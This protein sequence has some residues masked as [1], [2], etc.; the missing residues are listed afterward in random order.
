MSRYLDPTNDVAF[1]KI[2]GTD[3]HK[4]LL[5][6]FLNATLGLTG[7]EMIQTIEFLQK[8]QVPQI[9][10]NKLTILDVKCKTGQGTI[11][12][13]EIQNKVVPE[14]LKRTQYYASHCY[15]NQLNSGSTYLELSPVVLLAIVNYTLFPNKTGRVVSFHKTLDVESHEHDHQAISYAY[16]ELPKF[17]KKEDELQTVQD[18]WIF[19]LKNWKHSK[20]IPKSVQEKEIIEAYQ[21]I[22]QFGW[23]PFEMDEYVRA[24]LF[25]TDL[26]RQQQVSYEEGLEKGLQE[27]FEK[28][29]LEE[30][31]HLAQQLL[32]KG[33]SQ[34]EVSEMIQLRV[35]EIVKCSETM[36]KS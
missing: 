30:K 8:E 7:Q 11:F 31:F 4:P 20:E 2:F 25:R 27:G 32:T 17:E 15:V 22:E 23:N 16:I 12:I 19:F 10:D 28:G 29:R 26:Y 34:Q 18:K 3:D 36:N 1:K 9:K 35:E 14:F 21:A 6:S 13:V 33:F 5:I 24:N